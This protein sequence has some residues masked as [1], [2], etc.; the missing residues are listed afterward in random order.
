MYN[1]VSIQLKI[2]SDPF[3]HQLPRLKLYIYNCL[4]IPF[5]Y[6]FEGSAFHA[7]CV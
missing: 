5:N 2:A 3:F 7:I 1:W 6:T 4:F